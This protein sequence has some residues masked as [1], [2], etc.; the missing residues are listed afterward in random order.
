[1]F[2][3]GP[4]IEKNYK[5]FFAMPERFEPKHLHEACYDLRVGSEV[6]LSEGRV[7][8]RLTEENP[9]LVLPPGQFALVQTYEQISVPN[10]YVALISIRSQFKFQGLVNISGFHVDPTYKGHLI[11]AVQNVGPNDIRLKFKD[12][13]FMIMWAEL[14]SPYGG[15][16]RKQGY[17]CIPMDLMA[18]LGGPN[19]TLVSLEKRVQE[20]S[21]SLKIY[22]GFAIA[23]FLAVLGLILRSIFKAG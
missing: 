14:K 18:Q 6:F 20:L 5:Q 11:F 22:G 21:L 9:Y 3:D 2:I 8:N 15:E 12:P 23:A 19:V 16:P 7:P 1:M 17:E 4:F 13:T 10:N